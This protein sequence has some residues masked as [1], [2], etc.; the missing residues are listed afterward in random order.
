[1]STPYIPVA[2]GIIESEGKILAAQ[3]GPNMRH[4]GKW[5]FPGGKQEQGETLENC[6]RRELWEELQIEVVIRKALPA[7]LHV[8]GERRIMLY[9]F[10]CQLLTGQPLISEHAAIEWRHPHELGELDWAEADS[11]ILHMWLQNQ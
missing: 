1:L 10:V 8:Y 11:R 6:L 5:E 7:I 3:R 2:C 4:P 9:P